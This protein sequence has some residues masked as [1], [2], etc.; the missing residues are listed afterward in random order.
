MKI[1]LVT[2]TLNSEAFLQKTIESVLSQEGDF[3][4]EYIIKDGGSTDK[5]RRIVESYGDKVRMHIKSDDGPADAINQGMRLVT[6][7][8]AGWLGSDDLLLPGAL[9]R[10]I[11]TFTHTPKIKWLTGKSITINEHGQRSH[12]VF[13]QYADLVG[14][15]SG[16]WHL[17]TENT[18]RQPSTF[19]KTELW[20]DV[21]GLST[22]Y[23]YA[24]D[25][26]L[27]LR[28]HNAAG[29]P[30]WLS[31]DLSAFRRHATSLSEMHYGKQFEEE[32]EIGKKY[33]NSRF[34][35]LM[36]RLSVTRNLIAYKILSRLV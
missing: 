1:S 33:S 31:E 25:Y 4:L 2:P 35:H 12:Q 11:S 22:N 3:E 26:D 32:L 23:K 36:H 19:W 10:V 34:I 18:I 13:K 29:K 28:F 24:F 27:W 15:F 9:K 7:E 21:G 17:L 16:K 14:Q 6:G 5:T 20:H 8:I 30:H